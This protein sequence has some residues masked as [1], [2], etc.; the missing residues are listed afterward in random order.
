M[1]LPLFCQPVLFILAILVAKKAFKDY[2]T[3]EEFLDLVPP[4]DE[5]YPL[6]WSQ[7]VIDLPF[8]EGMSANAVSGKIENANAFSKRFRGL[9]S[10]SRY[11]RPPTIH[12]FRAIGLYLV[13]M[14]THSAYYSLY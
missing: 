8:F 14:C 13:V 5:M 10:R 12:D 1:P 6:R 4:D 9:G 3:I 7:N 2:E 11:I